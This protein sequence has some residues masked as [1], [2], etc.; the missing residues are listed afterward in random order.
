MTLVQLEYIVAVDTWRH[1]ATAAEH[2]FVTQPTLSMQIQKLEEALDLKIFDRSKHPVVPTP[3]GEVI[4][5]QARS[6][7]LARE[8]LM[9]VVQ[10]QKGILAGELRVGIIPTLAPYLLPL[11]VPGFLAH[12]PHVKLIVQELMTDDL[13][14]KLRQGKLDAGILVT[15]LQ[16]DDILEHVLFY[17]E[18]KVYMSKKHRA[19]GKEYVLPEDIDPN[20]LWLLEEGHCFRSQIMN[21]CE[22]QKL[23]KLQNHFDYEA[24]SI[25]TLRKMV[26]LN[27]GITIIPEMATF[28]MTAKQ[29]QLVRPFKRPF[30]MREVSLVVH[31]N[32]AK[33][34][35]IQQ[36][37]KEILAALPEKLLKNRSSNVI[38]I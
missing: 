8:A 32:Q 36:L 31:R 20:K 18:L 5:Q 13:L 6:V 27:E 24:G 29:L 23:S 28:D 9:Q 14:E 34:R 17:E 2:C 12:H 11:F 4:L 35:L 3:A 19:F 26:E 21:L 25:E 22:L 30:P 1:F 33:E 7:L 37:K 10:E 16:T 15:P 38:P